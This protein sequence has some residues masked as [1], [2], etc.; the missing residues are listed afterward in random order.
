MLLLLCCDVVVVVVVFV[1]LFLVFLLST[2]L[3]KSVASLS[4][5]MKGI[6]GLRKQILEIPPGFRVFQIYDVCKC[7]HPDHLS[8][9]PLWFL[10]FLLLLRLILFL[11]YH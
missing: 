9:G 4:L 8:V 3:N 11:L 2:L 10:L 6:S 7:N 5:S 1:V